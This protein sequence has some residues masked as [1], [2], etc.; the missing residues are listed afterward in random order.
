[1]FSATVKVVPDKLNPV[2]AVGILNVGV[3]VASDAALVAPE[4]QVLV[5]GAL[6][7]AEICD[8]PPCSVKVLGFAEIET[9]HAP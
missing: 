1:M 2:T 7:R 9:T 5:L 8:V 4:D 6:A 3:P